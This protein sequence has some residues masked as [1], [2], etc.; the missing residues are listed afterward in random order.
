MRIPDPFLKCV[1][2][3]GVETDVGTKKE[4]KW[5]GTAFL[6]SLSSAKYKSHTFV[7]LVT[8]RHIL[9]EIAGRNFFIRLN[10]KD[11][12]SVTIAIAASRLNR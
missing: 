7:Y 3:V 10:T 5:S 2:F 9:V 6:V 11:G 12:K 8:A 1:V 4:I